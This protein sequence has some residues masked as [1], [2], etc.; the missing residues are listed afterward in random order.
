MICLFYLLFFPTRRPT[1]TERRPPRAS[2][3]WRGGKAWMWSRK[4]RPFLPTQPKIFRNLRKLSTGRTK[5]FLSMRSRTP[6]CSHLNCRLVSR[7]LDNS[8]Y[9]ESR[10]EKKSLRILMFF[11]RQWNWLSIN[12]NLLDIIHKTLSKTKI[13]KKM[14]MKKRI[15]DRNFL[16][17]KLYKFLFPL[18]QLHPLC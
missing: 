7:D 9:L 12:V 1:N 15:F 3:V 18:H 6:L 4:F 17:M 5:L 13:D 8:L 10:L 2:W 11:F 16:F 14:T